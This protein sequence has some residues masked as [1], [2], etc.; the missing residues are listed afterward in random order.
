M[1]ILFSKQPTTTTTNKSGRLN[2][3]ELTHQNSEPVPVS[4]S[5]GNKLLTS[6]SV[7]LGDDAWETIGASSSDAFS[8]RPVDVG[9]VGGWASDFDALLN[10]PVGVKAFQEFSRREFCQ[11]S[12]QFFLEIQDF[13][14]LTDESQVRIRIFL[15]PVIGL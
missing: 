10:D 14:K 5:K 9:W 1:F 8:E 11:E 2:G 7:A 3:S 15:N 13:K 6:A 12:L 4:T